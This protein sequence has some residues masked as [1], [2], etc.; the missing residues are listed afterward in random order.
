M[1]LEPRALAARALMTAAPNGSRKTHV[2]ERA[3]IHIV[4]N[5]KD[6]GTRKAIARIKRAILLRAPS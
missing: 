5:R 1:G 6:A 2:I 4:S 3:Y